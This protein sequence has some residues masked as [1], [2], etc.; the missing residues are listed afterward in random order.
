MITAAQVLAHLAHPRPTACIE[1]TNCKDRQRELNQIVYQMKAIWN[2]LI[3]V[4]KFAVKSANLSIAGN[5]LYRV[6]I[7]QYHIENFH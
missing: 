1:F 3:I 6:R 7:P 4:L 5:L 2:F